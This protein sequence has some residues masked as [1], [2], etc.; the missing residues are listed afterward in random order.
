MLGGGRDRAVVWDLRIA[1]EHRRQGVGRA[2][3]RAADEWARA[4]GCTC[5]E[6]ETQQINVAAC[7]RYAR[8]GF[9]L[10]AVDPR[11]YADH[12][13]EIQ[14]IWTKALLPPAASPEG[15]SGRALP[16]ALGGLAVIGLLVLWFAHPVCRPLSR[17][18]VAAA[19]VWGAL[20]ARP[21][22]Q[23]HGRIWQRRGDQWF[24]CKSWISRKLFF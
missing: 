5:L 24:H 4:R 14:L 2:L 21:D 6:V 12:P 17:E 1:P 16:V 10:R 7:A 3:L 11:A 15:R 22:R 13:D 18:E 23:L 20:E 19:E 8:H 9:R